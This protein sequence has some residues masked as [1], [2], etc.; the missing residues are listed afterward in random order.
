MSTPISRPL[1]DQ[2]GDALDRRVALEQVHR[3]AKRLERFDERIIAPQDHL[4]IELAIDPPF[5]DSLDVAEVHHHVAVVETVGADVDLDRRVVSVRVLAH[6]V[7]VEQPV[8][9]T[10][11]DA[12]GHEIH[13]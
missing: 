11:L 9:V 7:I 10:E 6:A 8:A 1:E 3:L 13:V 12:F 5:D 2:P 4:V